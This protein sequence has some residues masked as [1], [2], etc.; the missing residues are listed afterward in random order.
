MSN[1]S[2]SIDSGVACNAAAA[3]GENGILSALLLNAFC[4]TER[5]KSS[6]TLELRLSL[7]RMSLLRTVISNTN[8]LRTPWQCKEVLW[9]ALYIYVQRSSVL[10]EVDCLR[11]VPYRPC[12][13]LWLK[14]LQMLLQLSPNAMRSC[15]LHPSLTFC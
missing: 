13:C 7:Q 9:G 8:T 14:L 12:I 2:Y 1:T 3:D 6:V 15:G 10:A 11:T 4:F 5:L